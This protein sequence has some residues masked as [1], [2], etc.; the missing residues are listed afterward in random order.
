[1][2]RSVVRAVTGVLTAAVLVAVPV[3][4]ALAGGGGKSAKPSRSTTTTTTATTTTTS[5]TTTTTTTA[6]PTVGSLSAH[7]QLTVATTSDWTQVAFTPGSVAA[8]HVTSLAGTATPTAMA[9]GFKLTGVTGAATAVVDL[10]F[11]DASAASSYTIKITKGSIG[12]T[13]VDVENLNATTP[14]HVVRNLLDTVTGV[15]GNPVSTTVSRSDLFTAVPMPQPRADTRALTLAFYYPWF[16]SYADPTLADQP[17]DPRTSWDLAGVTS[18]T[19]QAKANGVDGF[20]VS[21][22]GDTKD[23]PGFDVAK[24]AAESQGQYVTGYIEVPRAKSS[25]SGTNADPT[26]VRAWLVQL[27]ARQSSPA[28]LKAQDGVPVVFV[29]GMGYLQPWHWG[30]IEDSLRNDYGLSVHLVGDISTAA[31][32]PYE[33]GVHR[34]D[35]L[36]S[37]SALTSYS[38]NASLAARAAAVADPSVAPKLYVGT[39]SPG[40]DDTKLRGTLHPV[41]SR[42][43]TR[44]VDTWAAARAG[45]PDWVVVT[46]WNEWFEDSQIEPGTATGARALAETATESAAF[47]S[48]PR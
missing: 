35:I 30:A 47:R 13:T 34:Y 25:T 1:V 12:S 10:V 28:F 24:R 31:Y 17:Q 36:D 37:I 21:Y 43:G 23:G 32:L 44:Y 5:S 40:F 3:T 16:A 38:R 2:S 42:D 11:Y 33:W 29:Y 15:V 19:A 45:Q 27:L 22:A 39:A 6:S 14:V 41:V 7:L 8:Q 9:A 48:A 26:V 4:D 18:M 46:S 20:V